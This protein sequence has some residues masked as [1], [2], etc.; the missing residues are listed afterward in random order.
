MQ[1]YFRNEKQRVTPEK[2]QKILARHGTVVSLENARIILEFLY[3]L[4]NL[5]VSEAIKR[6]RPRDTKISNFKNQK[7]ENC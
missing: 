3:K 6:I 2:V 1:P 4:S 7:H 5:S